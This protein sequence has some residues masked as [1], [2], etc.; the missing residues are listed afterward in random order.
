MTARSDEIIP[1]VLISL[2]K[3]LIERENSPDTWQTLIGNQSH[4]RDYFGRI[5]LELVINEIDGFAYLTQRV[6][7]EGEA[8]LPRLVV[9]RQLSYRISLMLALLRKRLAEHDAASGEARLVLTSSEIADLVRLFRPDATNEAKLEDQVT[10]DIGKV[11]E[12]GFLKPLKGRAD[13]FEVRTILRSFVDAQWLGQ[14]NERLAD[15]LA[16]A[17]GDSA[18]GS[19]PREAQS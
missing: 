4:V 3:G 9:R 7:R 18:E 13:S 12:L 5:G 6:P 1:H 10:Q 15:Y 8:E 17:R 2:L 19:P 11:V 14:L 16:F